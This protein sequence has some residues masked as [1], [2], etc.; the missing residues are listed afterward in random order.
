VRVVNYT[1][2]NCGNR[3]QVV[4]GGVTNTYTPNN[5]NQYTTG[6]SLAVTNGPSHEI[7]SYNGTTYNYI[8]DSYL[9]KA[10]SGNNTLLLFYDPLGR[11]VK[12]TLTVNGG[13]PVSNYYVFDGEHWVVEY[14]S[15]GTIASN[16]LY[17]R[18]MDE[19]IARGVNGV[20][21]WYFPDRNGNTSVVT[22]GINT[23]RESYRYDAFG[24]PSV[25]S[26]TGTYLGSGSAIGN[27]FTFTGREW[28]SL[29]GFFE[30]RARAYNPTLGRF[31]SEDPKG[32]DAGDYNLYRYCHNDPMD[33][34]DPMGL[35][36][37]PNGDGTFHFVLRADVNLNSRLGGF[38]ASARTGTPYQ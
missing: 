32:F 26:G 6:N 5:L 29:F 9:A 7:S 18:G 2:D 34:S 33:L 10:V 11:C 19:V 12:R 13:T 1:L 31:M 17:G 37:E 24:L 25:Y 8:A 16:V 14:E 27:R 4:D 20:G 23:V 38:V 21:W 15:D 3:T 22:D 28:R 36:P 30:Y 35:D